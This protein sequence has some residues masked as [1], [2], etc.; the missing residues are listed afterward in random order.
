M[1]EGGLVRER[2]ELEVIAALSASQPLGWM[3]LLY[4]SPV[5]HNTLQR[6]TGHP[7]HQRKYGPIPF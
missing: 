3:R 7:K 6:K 5:F 1:D 4:C 2:E